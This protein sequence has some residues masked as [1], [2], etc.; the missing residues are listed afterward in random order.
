MRIGKL[1]FMP[2]LVC[3]ALLHCDGGTGMFSKRM[4]YYLTTPEFH[5]SFFPGDLCT[6]TMS[7]AAAGDPISDV[8]F[9]FEISYDNASS[10]GAIAPNRLPATGNQWTWQVPAASDSAFV[11]SE[12]CWIRFY[13]AG[14]TTIDPDFKYELSNR[15]SIRDFPQGDSQHTLRV[16]YPNGGETYF[17]NDSVRIR[18]RLAPD[19][20]TVKI[21]ALI[22][23]SLDSGAVWS[24]LDTALAPIFLTESGTYL[25]CLLPDTASL[26]CLIKVA[27]TALPNQ[28]T[29][30]SDH[31]FEIR[32]Y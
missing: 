29:D 14:N 9:D 12:A 2:A 10:F 7:M 18:L 24:V 27:D 31:C 23:L 6:L 17:P 30:Q 1:L 13:M 15:F 26:R 32:H 16:M 3:F 19:T 22:Y 20:A 28:Y 25:K 4:P 5:V 21:H 8:A 11:A